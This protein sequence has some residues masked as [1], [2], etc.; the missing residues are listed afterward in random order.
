MTVTLENM[1]FFAYHGCLEKERR[2]GN[3]FRVDIS[4][5]YDMTLAAITDDVNQAVN[6]AEVYAVVKT[7][8]EKPSNLLET[9]ADRILKAVKNS[10]PLIS[11]AKIT[12]AK[13]NPPVGGKVALSS[14]SMEF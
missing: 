5:D 14:V 2:E 3:L 4:Y 1:E 9:V 8:M 11:S 12:I 13:Y 10:F 7:E 6:Y